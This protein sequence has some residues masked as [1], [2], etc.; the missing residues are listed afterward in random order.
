VLTFPPG[1]IEYARFPKTRSLRGLEPG[2]YQLVFDFL[3]ELWASKVLLIADIEMSQD[4]K[5]VTFVGDVQS[6]SH[7]WIHRRRYG[8]ATQ[9]RGEKA[10]YAYIDARIPVRIHYIFRIEQKLA[11]KQI[12]TAEC[13]VVSRFRP[14]FTVTNFPWDLW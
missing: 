6:F 7:V 4:E 3:Q 13:A 5:A 2:L 12:L 1:K 9:Q 11:S 10:Q 8:A 14:S